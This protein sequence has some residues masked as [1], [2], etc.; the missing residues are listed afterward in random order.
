MV[1]PLNEVPGAGTGTRRVRIEDGQ[2][3]T[4]VHITPRRHLGVI[5]VNALI[6]AG[7]LF[8]LGFGLLL[9]GADTI[10]A[11]G[12]MQLWLMIW[13]LGVIWMLI[14]FLWPLFGRERWTATA[15]ALTRKT[16]ILGIGPTITYAAGDISGLRYVHDDAARQVRVNGRHVPQPALQFHLGARMVSFAHGIAR[17]DADKVLSAFI[18]RLHTARERHR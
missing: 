5:L 13:S 9:L 14:N 12:F 4:I 16:S 2:G 7:G 10:G 6:L 17:G 18:Q 1:M 8:G 15:K 11:P 3:E